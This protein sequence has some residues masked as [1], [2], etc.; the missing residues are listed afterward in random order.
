M[1]SLL[2]VAITIFF[3]LNVSGQ[4]KVIIDADTANEVDDIVSIA[5]ALMS[6]KI[7][8]IGLTVAQWPNED[9]WM[10]KTALESWELN[11]S[12]LELLDRKKTSLIISKCK[13]ITE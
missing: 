4:K 12:I 1:K 6:D 13:P 5:R 9:S 3:I 11:N 10:K 7:E 2:F 8:V